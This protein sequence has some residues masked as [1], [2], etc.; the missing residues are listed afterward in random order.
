MPPQLPALMY[1]EAVWKQIEKK[2][3]PAEGVVDRTRIAQLG[4]G[5]TDEA[6]GRLL[7]EIAAAA[8]ANDLD[9]EGAL[10]RE[11]LRIK[12]AIEKRLD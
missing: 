7:F 1:A 12:T 11:T 6:L 10:R 5:L 2:Q 8:R 4:A 9:S 3:L